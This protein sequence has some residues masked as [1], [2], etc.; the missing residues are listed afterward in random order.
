MAAAE[1]LKTVLKDSSALKAYYRFEASA[2]TT[3]SSGNS[4]T[5]TAV[6]DPAD[7]TGVFGGGVALDSD[8]C[9]TIVDHANLKP[10]GAFTIGAWINLNASG[11]NQ[12]IFQSYSQ[13]SNVAGIQFVVTAAGKLNCIIGDNTGTTLNTDYKDFTANTTLSD[14]TTYFVVVTW[15]TATIRIYL[16]GNHDGS[17]ASTIVPGYAATNYIRVGAANTSGT[18]INFFNGMMDDL[19]LVNG[20]ALS[21]DQIKELYEGRF[22]GELRPNQFG[23]ITALYHLSSTTDFSGNNRHLTNNN[24]VGFVA[25]RFGNC[26]DFGASNTNK[27]LLIASDLGITGGAITISGWYKQ[28]TEIGSG[29]QIFTIQKDGASG[30]THTYYIIR[31]EYNSGTRRIFIGRGKVGVGEQGINHTITLGTANWYHLALTYDTTNVT[32][33]INGNIV[34]TPTAAS[35][36]GSIPTVDGFCI[37]ADTDGVTLPSSIFADEVMVSSTA[38]TANQIR[39]MYALGVGK[40]Y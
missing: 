32:A 20:T 23:T 24:T 9:Y 5:L 35:G 2:L 26:A 38:L 17:V 1:L 30:N 6:S 40:Y 12:T 36:N 22:L 29:S 25:G 27:S 15:D 21:A 39:T 7:T 14:G 34:G 18:N 13:N 4:H 10:T 37:A 31:Y 16:N 28:Q 19:F 11:S 8:D 33:Y 3:D